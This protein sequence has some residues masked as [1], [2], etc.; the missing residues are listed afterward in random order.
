M[1]RVQVSIVFLGIEMSMVQGKILLEW[2]QIS[3]G[4]LDVARVF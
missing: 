4:T 1:Y 2:F 3:L